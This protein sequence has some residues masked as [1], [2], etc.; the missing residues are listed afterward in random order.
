M[1]GTMPGMDPAL[2]HDADGHLRLRDLPFLHP[3]R[4]MGLPAGY[5]RNVTSPSVG[6]GY[7]ILLQGSPISTLPVYPLLHA[8]LS[9]AQKTIIPKSEACQSRRYSQHSRLSA[10]I[11]ALQRMGHH[12]DAAAVF[13][14]SVLKNTNK[15]HDHIIYRS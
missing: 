5:V 1:D 12:G 10:G 3:V 11:S 9:C 6:S 8:D 2:L 15:K 4:R 7:G 13:I 14:L